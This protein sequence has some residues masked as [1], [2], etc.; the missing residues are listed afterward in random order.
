MHFVM[1]NTPVGFT[2]RLGPFAFV[3]T[4]EKH[5]VM[6]TMYCQGS[7]VHNGRHIVPTKWSDEVAIEKA[8]RS[9][10]PELVD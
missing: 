5:E 3:A 9:A 2:G 6:L 4:R 10:I 7:L 1:K 8:V